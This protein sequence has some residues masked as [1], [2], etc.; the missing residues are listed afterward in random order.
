VIL[1]FRHKWIVPALYADNP[2]PNIDFSETPFYLQLH[3]GHWKRPIVQEQ[4]KEIEYPRRAGI[5]SFGAGGANAHIIVEEYIDDRTP[6]A[7]SETTEQLIVLSV[8]SK[9]QVRAYTKNISDFI[10]AARS[11]K[12]FPES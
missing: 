7:N 2:N 4:G 8:M 6:D 1:Q 5:S 11:L 10:K 3:G 9:E 12:S